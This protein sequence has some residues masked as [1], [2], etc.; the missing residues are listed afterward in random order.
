VRT[1]KTV[2]GGTTEY[3]LDPA[4]A[5][6]VVISDTEVVY[7]YGLD[8]IAQANGGRE[9]LLRYQEPMTLMSVELDRPRGFMEYGRLVWTVEFFILNGPSLDILIDPQSGKIIEVE[10]QSMSGTLV[11]AGPTCRA[12]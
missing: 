4:A 10:E 5:P 7:V 11:A 12:A 1:S 9:F 3:V 2:A 8:I 6:P